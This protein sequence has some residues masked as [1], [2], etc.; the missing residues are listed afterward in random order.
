VHSEPMWDDV[1]D[2]Y[3][4]VAGPEPDEPRVWGVFELNLAL[5][6]L[7]EGTLPS[8]MVAGEVGSWTRAKS[9]HCYFSLKDDRAQLRAVMWRAQ[10]AVL[11]VDPEEGMRVRVEGQVTLYEARG[12]MQLVVRR[13]DAE[14]EDGLWKLAFERLRRQLEREGLLDPARRRPLPRFPQRVGVVTSPTGAAFQDILSVLRRRAPWVRVTLAGTRVQGEGASHEIARAL[15]ALANSGKVDVILIGRGG[16]SRED[17]WAFNEEPVVRAIARSP[18][19]VISAVGHETDVTLADL[20]ADLRAP[21][22]SAAAEAAVPER[23]QMEQAFGHLRTRLVRGLRG[24]VESRRLRLVR[25]RHQL[26]R[27]GWGIVSPRRQRLD[28]LVSALPAQMERWIRKDREV[29]RT[30]A[31]QLNVLSPLATLERGYTVARGSDG[32]LL[33]SQA[34]FKPGQSFSLRFVDGTVQATTEAVIP[35]PLD[36]RAMES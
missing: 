5:R 22:P 3:G 12:E 7:L 17:L 23:A 18:V 30:L 28:R 25:L 31:A 35:D 2:A 20:V 16:G 10:A 13:L 24:Q 11:P 1:S 6:Q 32:A 21:T 14:G 29:L 33:R 36:Q 9:G 15:D 27:V 8:V 4:A 26:E 34:A 19:P